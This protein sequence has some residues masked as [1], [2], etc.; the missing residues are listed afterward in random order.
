MS[1]LDHEYQKPKSTPKITLPNNELLETKITEIVQKITAIVGST[2]GPNG[3]TILIERPDPGLPPYQTKDGVTVIRQMSEFDEVKQLILEMF[4]DAAIKTVE[5]AGDGTTTATILAGSILDRLKKYLNKNKKIS[6]Q[7]AARELVKYLNDEILPYI[8]KSSLKID[9]TNSQE[10]LKKVAK[11]STNGDEELTNI[12]IEAF[13]LIGDNGHITIVEEPGIPGYELIKT[14]GY[15]FDKGYEQS[16]GIFSNEFINDQDANR[17]LLDNPHYLLIDGKVLELNP[18]VPLLSMVEQEVQQ[19]KM[20]PNVVIMAHQFSK[21]VVAKLAQWWKVDGALKILP[22][23]TPMDMLPNS[24]YDFLQDMAAFTGGKVFNTLTNPVFGAMPSDLGKPS[25]S[26]ECQRYRSIV[27]GTGNEETVLTRVKSILSQSKQPNT[28]KL[29][30]S[31]LE[32]RAGRLS[33]GIAKLVI[34]GVSDAQNRETRDRAEDAIC[35]IR[36]AIKHGVL[37]G[38]GRILLNL[39]LIAQESPSD[40]V[41]E[42]LAPSL[43]EPLFRLLLNCGLSAEEISDITERLVN[44]PSHVYDA[45]GARFGLPLD[46]DLLDSAPAVKESVRSALSIAATLSTLGGVIV[47]PRN[48]AVDTAESLSFHG[49]MRE[50]NESSSAELPPE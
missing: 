22:C 8:E 12:I 27:H 3:Q 31:I 39:S 6:K 42:V 40:L 44:N 19:G 21:E 1:F 9:H 35:A 13:E 29:A 30:F 45:V 28:T 50:L 26:F 36:G 10:L 5:N 48:V 16:L 14:D 17:V 25:T 20:S 15:P 37:P 33:G 38:G 41:K 23:V 47:Q 34:R 49:K 43:R 4:R 7:Y 24:Q 11:V 2:L 18:I 32:E 46:L